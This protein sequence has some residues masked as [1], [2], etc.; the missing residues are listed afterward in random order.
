MQRFGVSLWACKCLSVCVCVCV[1]VCVFWAGS[2]FQSRSRF[3]ALALQS[4]TF[5]SDRV[6]S[7]WLR[8]WPR[9]PADVGELA[10]V[11]RFHWRRLDGSFQKKKNVSWN[12]RRHQRR[13]GHLRQKK[14]SWTSLPSRTDQLFAFF[15]K[16][17]KSLLMLLYPVK[18]NK[19]QSNPV[20]SSKTH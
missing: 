10:Q 14:T 12:R 9:R 17:S 16:R 8:M 1:C 18:P 15:F 4:W 2:V 11:G 5:P 3:A 6:E 13:R 19:K 20:K 7:L